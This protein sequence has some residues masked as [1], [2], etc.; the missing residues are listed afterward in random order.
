MLLKDKVAL[1]TGGG[2]NIGRATAIRFARE[3]AR[4]VLAELDP[5]SGERTCREIEAAGGM[6]RFV[7]TDVGRRDQVEQLIGQTIEHFAGLDILVNNPAITGHR[8]QFLEVPQED[9]DR[10]IAVNQTGVFMCSQLAAR[11]MAQK[12]GGNIVH[13]TSVNAYGPQPLNTT[14]GAA[15]GAL[16]A[17]TRSMATDLAPHHIRVNAI[18]PGPIHQNL[19]DR[20]PPQPSPMPLLGR[21]GLPREIAAAALFLCSNQSQF[22]TGQVLTVDG[23]SRVNAYNIYA[24]ERPE[25]T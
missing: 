25:S 8:V 6:A 7:Q 19:P 21:F 15:K 17:L 22:I 13:I 5:E 10:I 14:Y 3:G 1:I 9:W 16:L 2:R 20:A 23:G 11:I 18:A 24:A 12:N 4:T